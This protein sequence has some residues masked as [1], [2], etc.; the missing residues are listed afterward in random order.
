MSEEAKPKVMIKSE[1]GFVMTKREMKTATGETW[2][3]FAKSPGS[4]ANVQ[5]TAKMFEEHG[6][7][8]VPW[9]D[10]QTASD[11][12]AVF[13]TGKDAAQVPGKRPPKRLEPLP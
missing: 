2:W 13:K 11:G 6:F 10:D 9:S 8:V 7:E 5:S 4:G 3:Q 12:S 1:G